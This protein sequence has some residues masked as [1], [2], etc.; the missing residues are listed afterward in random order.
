MSIGSKFEITKISSFSDLTVRI[1]SC[2]TFFAFAQF[3][4]ASVNL[5]PLQ[6]KFGWKSGSESSTPKT[7]S[8]GYKDNIVK[9]IS[10]F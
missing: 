6:G 2:L 4:E 1:P 8:G 9:Q 7:D 3:D 5:G 10:I